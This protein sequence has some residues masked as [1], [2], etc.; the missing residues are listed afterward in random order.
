MYGQASRAGP[1]Q[2]PGQGQGPS[3][4]LQD[5]RKAGLGPPSRT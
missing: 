4:S 2:A 3:F 1:G 5:V